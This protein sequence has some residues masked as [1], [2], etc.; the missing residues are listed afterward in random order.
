MYYHD[1]GSGRTG[2]QKCYDA[3]TGQKLWASTEL[4]SIGYYVFKIA[5]GKVYGEQADAS[6]TTGRTPDPAAFDCWDAF[7]GEII[8]TLHQTVTCPVVAYGNLYIVNSGV[9]ICFSTDMPP[10]NWYEFRGNTAWPGIDLSSGP[11]D[12]SP[13]PVWTYQAGGPIIA[14]MTVADGKVFFGDA[15]QNIYALD[16]YNGSVIWSFHTNQPDNV[17]W[18]S[19]LAVYAGVV[20]TGGDDGNI[21]GLDENTGKQLWV[22]NAGPWIPCKDGLGQHDIR[23]SPIIYNGI[24]YLARSTTRHTQSTP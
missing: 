2:A 12:F 14:S 22:V 10:T 11:R 1:L 15:D 7:T 18:G 21:Y 9:L 4:H 6:T 16:A 24:A 8:W 23:S 17:E 5:D 20:I 3:L 19:T 13:G